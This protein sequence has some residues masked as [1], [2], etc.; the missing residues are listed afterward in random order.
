[1]KIVKVDVVILGDGITG[2]SA[3]YWLQKR[4][5]RVLVLSKTMMGRATV[6]S[7]GMLTPSAEVEDAGSVLI[8]FALENCKFYPEFVR[9]IEYESS[10]TCGLN[11]NG[12]LMPA[13]NYDDRLQLEHL[14]VRQANRG[15]ETVWLS[16]QEARKYEPCLS[17]KVIGSLWAP[18]DNCVNPK[19]LLHNLIVASMKLGA[20]FMQVDDE[21]NLEIVSN[22]VVGVHCS[23]FGIETRV[24]ARHV[25]A[26]AGSWINDVLPVETQLPMRPVKGQY[27]ELSG[28][29]LITRV[30]RTPRAYLVPRDDGTV[31]LGATSEEQGFD[32]SMVSGPVFELYG[33]AWRV[34]PGVY[35]SKIRKI[36]AGLRPALRDNL[37]AIG[38]TNIE[39]LS[40]ITGHYR[41]GIILAPLS[42][43]MLAKLI[44][45]SEPD[46][47]AKAFSPLRFSSEDRKSISHAS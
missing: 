39:G 29:D 11:T 27:L 24:I 9:M 7:G 47:L 2:C 8:D 26:A 41:H 46:A 19:S 30:I 10:R 32:T 38:F 3:A 31:F 20:L 5:H 4:G 17:P 16:G 44:E 42:G 13:L 18:H 35:E 37:P 22:R 28:P 14:A 33:H 43:L 23:L 25:V 15:I 36:G 40:V 45:G 21:P 12:T 1:M 34:V 6:A